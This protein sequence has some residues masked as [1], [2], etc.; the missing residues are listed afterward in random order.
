MDVKS[1]L[2]RTNRSKADLLRELGLDPKSSLISSYI[3][4][5]SNPSFEVSVKLLQ[6]G[7]TPLELFGEEI[8]KKLRAY[9]S[10]SLP[11]SVENTGFKEGMD[12][13]NKP[14]TRAEAIELF[15]ELQAKKTI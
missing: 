6:L 11:H 13:A 3:A 5:R 1:F 2:D 14:L 10:R 4:G 12:M 8:D 7:M 15:N 9:Y